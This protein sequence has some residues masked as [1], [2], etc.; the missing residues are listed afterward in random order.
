MSGP[1]TDPGIVVGVD[2]SPASDAAVRW[3][4]HEA[5]MRNSAL[6]VVHAI[7]EPGMP[8]SQMRTPVNIGEWLRVE[9]NRI[10]AGAIEI[11]RSGTDKGGPAQINSELSFPAPVPALVHLS[12]DAEMVVVGCHGRSAVDRVLLGSVSTGLVH[13]AHCPV[14]VIHDETP[15]SADAPVV[16]GIDGSPASELATAIA[17]DEA[18]WRGVDLVALHAFDDTDVSRL[19]SIEWSAVA[20]RRTS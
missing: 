6:T 2:G 20:Y 10:I 5:A 1:R 8:W 14:A 16:V 7:A 9:G 17:F 13:H 12:H 18:S 15:L 19:P 4:A 11:A 3:V